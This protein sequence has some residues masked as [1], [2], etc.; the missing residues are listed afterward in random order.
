MTEIGG[1]CQYLQWW[2]EDNMLI[3]Y[4]L[5]NLFAPVISVIITR[6][7]DQCLCFT[8]RPLPTQRS[9]SC[10]GITA[11]VIGGLMK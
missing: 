1:P 9:Y 8:K 6:M 10:A 7:Y 2:N 4:N 3:L 5:L 11:Y